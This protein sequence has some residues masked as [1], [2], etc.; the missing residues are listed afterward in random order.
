M[1][2]TLTL[3]FTALS[4]FVFSQSASLA[5]KLKAIRPTTQ[6][7]ELLQWFFSTRKPERDGKYYYQ[8]KIESMKGEGHRVTFS[9][10]TIKSILVRGPISKMKINK[11]FIMITSDERMLIINQLDSFDKVKWKKNIIPGNRNIRLTKKT[12]NIYTISK[13]IFFRDNKLCLFKYA[14]EC[15]NRCADGQTVIYQKI[16]GVWTQMIVLQRWFS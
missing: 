4:V 12:Y 9:K 1:K 2:L 3:I 8:S 5:P 6:E 13:P 7:A 10:D 16:N 11:D 14:Y 15:G